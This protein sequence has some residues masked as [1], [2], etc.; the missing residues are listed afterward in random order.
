MNHHY[1]ISLTQEKNINKKH[2]FFLVEEFEFKKPIICWHFKNRHQ[3]H[4]SEFH[5][6]THLF[7]TTI[8]VITAH[9][10][11]MGGEEN[12]WLLAGRC[13]NLLQS[14][15]C[16]FHWLRLWTWTTS[17]PVRLERKS[18]CKC[19][20]PSIAVKFSETGQVGL[21]GGNF[22][23]ICGKIED[24]CLKN[25]FTTNEQLLLQRVGLTF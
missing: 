24:R 11:K 18:C 20:R 5:I 15:I 10:A 6:V 23:G 17:L 14:R 22:C 7:I 19:C 1:F 12:A 25:A 21:R 2:L 3:T 16:T 8:L 4:L 9:V 13:W